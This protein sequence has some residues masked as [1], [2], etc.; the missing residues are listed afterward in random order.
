MLWLSLQYLE[1]T[2]QVDNFKNATS[3]VATIV[4]A[5]A[6]G[7]MTNKIRLANEAIFAV[8][9]LNRQRTISAA[10]ELRSD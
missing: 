6:R 5:R 8:E 3:L 7:G 2:G 10:Y 4:M 9:K 1:G